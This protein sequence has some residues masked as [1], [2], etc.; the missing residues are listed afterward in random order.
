MFAIDLGNA[1][2]GFPIQNSDS[3]VLHSMVPGYQETVKFSFTG[4]H[5]QNF[6]SERTVSQEFYVSMVWMSG[7]PFLP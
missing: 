5:Y 7:V 4:N 6:T 2:N 3:I 1:Q